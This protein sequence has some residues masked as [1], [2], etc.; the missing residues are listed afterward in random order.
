VSYFETA[1]R[2]R[3]MRRAGEALHV[4]ASSIDRQILQA[5]ESLGVQLFE[6]LSTGLKLTAA[7][8]LVLHRLR[9]WQSEEEML[10]AQVQE[11]KGLR[12]G[13][14]KAAVIEGV[15]TELVASAT[16]EFHA[17]YPGVEFE[18]LVHG[19]HR[20]TEMVLA[21]DADFGIS[22]NPRL[23]PGLNVLASKP[24]DLGIV[25]PRGHALAGKKSVRLADCMPYRIV[26]AESS[27]DLRLVVD[28]MLA[29]SSAR[30]RAALS[31]NSVQVL[32]EMVRRGLGVG[33][34]TAFD[35]ERELIEDS[36]VFVRFADHSAPASHLSLIV[37]SERQ[38]SIAA[39][40]F[41]AAIERRL[42]N[43]DPSCATPR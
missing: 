32:K 11:L 28:H 26:I 21:G 17:Q 25:V 2:L 33:L 36:L 43:A 37:S 10:V 31:S 14:I 15:A 23:S 38:L 4:S 41:I 24:F 8:E 29:R 3:S 42:I 30:P 40:S 1:A 19:A 13:R 22:V 16:M 18:I 20:I 35:V 5:E 39:T 9:K 12:R 7:G 27:L 6:R 34:L